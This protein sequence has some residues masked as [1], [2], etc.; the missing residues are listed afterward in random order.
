MNTHKAVNTI[1]TAPVAK[2][3]AEID[4]LNKP[5]ARVQNVKTLNPGDHFNPA[6]HGMD[7]E[8]VKRLEDLGRIAKLEGAQ[9]QQPGQQPLQPGELPVTHS[10]RA[11]ETEGSGATGLGTHQ[12]SPPGVDTTGKAGPQQA[13]GAGSNLPA[14]GK[15]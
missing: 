2:T 9:T 14:G 13:G 1:T 5:N 8:E 6:D 12:N 11:N 15:K 3:P 10:E 4:V 7:A